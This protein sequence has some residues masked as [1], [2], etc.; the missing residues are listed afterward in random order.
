M[1]PPPTPS[2]FFVVPPDQ[3]LCLPHTQNFSACF[4]RILFCHNP[5]QLNPK[6]GRPYFPK[7]PHHNR[8]RTVR[9]F[10]SA[11]RQPN[12]TKFSMLPYF[13]PTRRFMQKKIG[14]SVSKAS[15][16]D[17]GSWL[18]LLF[19]YQEKPSLSLKLSLDFF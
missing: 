19:S 10:F 2:T 12:S 16:I 6:L 17:Q 14:P 7:K 13:N 4:V 9:H 1:W 3:N 15:L 8:N 18:N 11:P 5:I